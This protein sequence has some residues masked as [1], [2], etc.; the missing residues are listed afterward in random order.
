MASFVTVLA[1]F[2]WLP[3]ARVLGW[4]AYGLIH[5]VLWIAWVLTR[6]RYHAVY[7]DNHYLRLW[8]V[9]AYL[10][11]G[12]C[13]AVK[14]WRKRKYLIA[15]LATVLTLALAVLCS[16]RGWQNPLWCWAAHFP[17]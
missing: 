13:A 12:L 4:A 5:A 6:W 7:F 14:K 16:L 1:G 2:V 11:F 15:L 3:A 8:M 10:G 9:G 17:C